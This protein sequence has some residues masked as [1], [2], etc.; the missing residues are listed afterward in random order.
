MGDGGIGVYI[1]NT[2]RGLLDA[3]AAQIT[4]IASQAQA[5]RAPWRKEVSWVYDSSK[6]YSVNEYLLLPRRINFSPYDLYHS[7]HF[8]LPFGIPLPTIVTV[9]DLIHIEHPEAFYYPMIARRLIRSAVTRASKVVAVSQDTR[10]KLLQLTAAA[11]NKI[12]H[13]PNAIPSF[14]CHRE[15]SIRAEPLIAGERYFVTVVSNCKPHKGVQDLVR[16][17]RSF[18]ERYQRLQE[19]RPSPK[20]LLVGYGVKQLKAERSLRHLVEAT[21]G[22]RLIGAV[23]NDLLR[24]I[25]RGAEALVVPSLAEGFCLPALEAQSVGTRVICRPIAALLELVTEYDMVASD[26]SVD[27]F[28]QVLLEAA[29]KPKQSKALIDPHLERFALP[30]ISQQLATVYRGVIGATVS[31]STILQEVRK[32]A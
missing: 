10:Q 23:D 29:C 11:P 25:Y 1:Q 6:Q 19:G 31:H 2:I 14:V 28:V 12:V 9:H 32:S 8:T 13:I 7:P 26:I 17:W 30:L 24:Y 16:A 22:I 27:S 15:P 5:E 20:L 18:T 3:G 4:V 21:P